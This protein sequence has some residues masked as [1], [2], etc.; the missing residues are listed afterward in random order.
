MI[1]PP[2]LKSSLASGVVLALFELVC[3]SPV[4]ADQALPLASDTPE[5]IIV[6]DRIR[7]V[8]IKKVGYQVRAGDYPM[9]LPAII[10]PPPSPD[11]PSLSSPFW[12]RPF[13][14]SLQQNPSE[15]Q[16]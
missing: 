12:T 10:A 5:Q 6:V 7:R 16:H 11:V 3:L 4:C 15:L 2:M 1:H 13:V 9:A 14:L 8:G